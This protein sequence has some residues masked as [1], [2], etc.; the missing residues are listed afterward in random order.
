MLGLQKPAGV[1]YLASNPDV[2]ASRIASR[3]RNGENDIDHAYLELLH[4]AHVSYIDAQIA[5]GTPVHVVDATTLG[6]D[7][8]SQHR[9]ARAVLSWAAELIT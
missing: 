7:T 2:C 4:D 6:L 1:V 5:S 8:Q 3:A 9:A